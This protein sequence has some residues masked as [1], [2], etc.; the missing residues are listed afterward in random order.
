[1]TRFLLFLALSLTSVGVAYAEPP[2]PVPKDKTEALKGFKTRLKDEEAGRKELI[3]KVKKIDAEVLSLR[4]DLVSVAGL[5][6][7]NE[8]DLR[9][10][11]NK[12]DRLEEKKKEIEGKLQADRLSLSRLVVALERVARVPPEAILARPDTP[13][14]NAQSATLMKDIIPAVERH[15]QTLKVNL[16]TLENV[17]Q[18]LL[19]D[20]ES[21]LRV[22]DDLHDR[23][24]ELDKLL[25][26]R[27]GL[28]RKT[29]K[30]LQAKEIRIEQISLQAKN[31]EDLMARLEKD[32]KLELKKQNETI[33]NQTEIITSL[34][35]IEPAAA[36]RPGHRPENLAPARIPSSSLKPQL[37]IS[38]IVRIGYNQKDDVGAKSH[39][40]TIEGRP[41]ALVVAPMAGKVQFAGQFKRYGNIVIIEHGNGFH[42]LVA[43]LEKID[44]VVGQNV[45]TGEP[46]GVMP[47]SSLAARPKVYYELR[48]DGHPVNPAV[49]FGDLG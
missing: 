45:D 27:E 1:M 23:K 44:A 36:P 14:K 3:E 33:T 7:Q 4:R 37:P 47:D 8:N 25:Q 12:I 22:A 41:G 49:K 35:A 2:P 32:R 17:S 10:L 28:Y 21:S 46:L 31:L 30:D 11:E 16:E 40:L 34:E 20:K 13:Y 48:R 29:H 42:S 19:T 6:Q 39:G 43:G 5:V 18:E 9:E 26:K 24:E 15:A 38:G